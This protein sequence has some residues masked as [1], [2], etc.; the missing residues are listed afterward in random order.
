MEGAWAEYALDVC[1]YTVSAWSCYD[2]EIYRNLAIL[3]KDNKNLFKNSAEAQA[4]SRDLSDQLRKTNFRAAKKEKDATK[5]RR[6]RDKYRETTKD[7]Y[8]ENEQ[9]KTMIATSTQLRN[10]ED[11]NSDAE[12]HHETVRSRHENVPLSNLRNNQRYTF[13]TGTGATEHT[14]VISKN[15][16]YPDVD[17][18]HGSKE[19]RHK[20]ESWRL[21]LYA[22]FR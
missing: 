11:K 10:D 2:K 22:K 9:L 4:K 15:K 14:I 19:N 1:W 18:F 7:L 17:D 20:W 13:V 6:L 8:R 21:H 16:R 12:I 5:I 3:Q